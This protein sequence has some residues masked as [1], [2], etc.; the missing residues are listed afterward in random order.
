MCREE[1]NIFLEISKDTD[2]AF[3]TPPSIEVVEAFAKDDGPGPVLKPMRLCFDVPARHAWNIDLAE[4]FVQRFMRNH[5]V[6]ESEECLIYELF[7]GR[8]NSLKR[9]YNEWQ[10]KEGEDGVQRRQRVKE[11][12]KVER[13]LQRKDTR[14]NKVS[15]ISMIGRT[16]AHISDSAF[17]RSSAYYNRK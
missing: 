8:F 12:H 1:M 10:C 14:R 5:E 9:R 3:K 16:R 11:K 6:D 17:C 13:K 4:Q 15:H 7:N 2:I